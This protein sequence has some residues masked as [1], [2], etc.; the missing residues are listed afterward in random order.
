MFSLKYS[1]EGRHLY[2]IIWMCVETAPTRVY[3]DSPMRDVL[4]QRPSP[5]D[6]NRISPVLQALPTSPRPLF[7]VRHRARPIAGIAL[8]ACL[9]ALAPIAGASSERADFVRRARVIEQNELGAAHPAGLAWSRRADS[10]LVVPQ[11]DGAEMLKIGRDRP[12]GPRRLGLRFDDPLNVTFDN[13]AG[14]LIAYDSRAR[15][16]VAVPAGADGLPLPGRA[17]RVPAAQHRILDPQGLSVD[18]GTGRLFVLDAAGPRIAVLDPGPDGDLRRASLSTLDLDL[19]G[20]ARGLAFDPMTGHLHVLDPAGERLYEVG[21]DGTVVANRDLAEFSL[22]DPQA[23]VFAPSGDSTDDPVQTSLYVAEAGTAAG[24][25]DPAAATGQIAELSLVAVAQPAAATTA[26]ASLVQHVL[27]S[28]YDPPSPDSM[29]I[30]Y[31][32]A[33][34]T[35][36]M[37]DSELNEIPSLFTGDNIFEIDYTDGS[38]IGTASTLEPIRFSTEPVGVAFDP[39]GGGRLFISHDDGGGKFFVIRRGND[40]HYLTG[41]DQISEVPTGTFG[42]GDP[43][44][45]TFDRNQR[46]LYTADGV[47]SE[48]YRIA[49]GNDGVFGTGDDQTSH[50]DTA[51][52][53][54]TDPEGI[55]FDPISGNLYVSGNPTDKIYEFSISGTLVRVIDISAADPPNPSGLTVGPGSNN[56][57]IN[58]LYIVDR[59]KDNNSVS[60]ENDGQLYEVSFASGSP[61]NQPPQVNAGPD[62][63]VTLPASAALNATV[64]DDPQQTLSYQWIEVSGPGTVT[65]ANPNAVD[66][67]ASFSAAGSYVLRLTAND[68]QLS[69]SDEVAVAVSGAGGSSIVEVRVAASSDDA[70]EAVPG[71]SMDLTSSD[72][73]MAVESTEQLV[74]IRFAGVTV[75]RGASILDAWVQFKTDET[76]SSAA[77]L[78]IRGQY[79]GNAGT[80]TTASG[81]VSSRPQTAA[82]QTWSPPAWTSIGATGTGQRTPQLNAVIAEIVGHPSWASGN[83]LVLLI[84]GTGR[85]TAESF[86]GDAAGAPLLH[87]EYSTQPN[88]PPSVSISAPANGAAFPEGQSISFSGSASDNEDGNLTGSLAWTS[89]LDGPIGSGGSFARSDL[90][91]GSH[92]ITAAVTDSGGKSASAQRSITVTSSNTAPT[93]NITAPASGSS[94]VQ[95]QSVGFTGTATDNQDGNLSSSLVWSS[96]RDGGLGS[97]ASLT[98]SGL[99]VGTHTITASATD[100]G[101]LA[102]NAQ[103][104]V[105]ITAPPGGS[106]VQIQ[107]RVASG[108]DDTEEEGG[109]I[110]RGSSDLELI[111]DHV[112]QVVGIRFNGVAIPRGATIQQASVQFQCDETD[113]GATS[114]TI[115]AQAADSAPPLTTASFD[116]SSRPTT[117]AS[118][119]WAPP[120]W[121]TRGEAGP[122]QETTS[123]VAVIQEIVNRPGWASGNSLVLLITGS[124]TRTAEAYDGDPS[125]APLLKVTYQQ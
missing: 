87:I 113:S 99:S 68:G 58:N 45:I 73:E 85:R 86:N 11:G 114:L 122:A 88:D 50:F 34:D 15:Q 125:G 120:A 121:S 53:G 55:A 97:G 23:L 4:N 81:N 43:E 60:G 59:G 24:T 74:G 80:F 79:A 13:R 37:S 20:P 117:L 27:T 29:G 76:G 48:V 57:S 83:A 61:G 54:C 63:A 33:T 39:A 7:H 44:G 71:G 94:F 70:E 101:G 123:L 93:V 90:S 116:L 35:L 12:S 105:T 21:G 26:T 28:Q 103:I 16:L 41:D 1:R 14:R 96:S 100:S 118:A 30:A 17:T 75:P 18:P 119:S 124:G 5:R 10:L 98:T 106:P 110:S 77:A 95:G 36:L 6:P 67:T 51:S 109:P 3:P 31:I 69:G 108:D 102:S 46:V 112:A 42:D 9:G 52:A 38:L 107:V 115:R 72:L 92:T 49:P 40:G 91:P 65:F 22:D 66:T 111:F 47:D 2:A 25:A 56:P 8:L 89:S 82:L 84:G 104:S 19:P 62:L 78:T 64:T 32:D